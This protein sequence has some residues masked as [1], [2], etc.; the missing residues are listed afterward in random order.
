VRRLKSEGVASLIVE[1][2]TEIGLSVADRAAVI[3]RGH[4]AWTGEAAELRRD[5]GLRQRLLGA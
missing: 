5:A 4:I 2:N 1:Q 3:D